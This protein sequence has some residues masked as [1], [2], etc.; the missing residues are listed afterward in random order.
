[1][2]YKTT[3]GA[4][5][6]AYAG[7]DRITNPVYFS[8]PHYGNEHI[9]YHADRNPGITIDVTRMTTSGTVEVTVVHDGEQIVQEVANG[10]NRNVYIT[11]T[12][13]DLTVQ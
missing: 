10:S 6:E 8:G 12:P 1:M 13:Q 4:G 2:F 11:G 7:A 9:L 3:G 5:Y